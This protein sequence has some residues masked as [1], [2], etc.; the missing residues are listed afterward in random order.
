MNIVLLEYYDGDFNI[1]RTALQVSVEPITT[2]NHNL[3]ERAK[4]TPVIKAEIEK[5]LIEKGYNS[6]YQVIAF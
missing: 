4:S 3:D 1:G 6:R 5:Y 2:S